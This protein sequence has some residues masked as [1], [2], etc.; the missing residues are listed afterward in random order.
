LKI[1]ETGEHCI[2]RKERLGTL[3]IEDKRHRGTLHIE[4]REIGENWILKIRE[5]GE[6]CILRSFIIT[7]LCQ[8][9]INQ[10]ILVK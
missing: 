10:S 1:R 6:H 8:V 3:N 9:L 4:E 7:V 2:L 5:I